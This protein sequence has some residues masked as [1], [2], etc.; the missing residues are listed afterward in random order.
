MEELRQGPSGLQR[1]PPKDG[2]SGYPAVA[3]NDGAKRP[4]DEKEHERKAFSRASL[5]RVPTVPPEPISRALVERRS[6]EHPSSAPRQGLPDSTSPRR[7][8]QP[9]H[10][11]S[12]TYPRVSV[13]IPALNEAKNL[14]YV[15]ADLPDDVFEVV[16]VDGLSTDDTVDV[17]RALYPDV[18]IVAQTGRGKGNAL[19]CG[20]NA[21][22]GDVIV[23][24]DA[25]GSAK[26]GEIPRFVDA[27]RSGAD[28]AKG[29]RFV[30]GG[31]SAD[32]TSLRRVG[33]WFFSTLVNVFFGTRYSDLCYGYNAFWAHCLPHIDV[34]CD[35]F[36]VE[37]LIN[38]R[39]AKAGLNVAEVASYEEER[40]HGESNLRTFR[41]GFRVLMTIL[42]ETWRGRPN[43]V[44]EYAFV[45]ADD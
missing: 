1:R 33:N 9:L 39:V 35:G 44:P 25:D 16:L 32:I 3:S 19:A 20:F 6:A 45:T 17:A 43:G 7:L 8:E 26:A 10:D 21:C 37:T 4:G 28:F 12:G 40:I 41:D 18:R 15:F 42:R 29:S 30:H 27:L 34:D 31:G 22:R 11:A 5:R 13:V 36:E 2:G 14:P 38:I 24:L 23:M